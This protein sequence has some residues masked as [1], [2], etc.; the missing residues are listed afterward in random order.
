MSEV[1]E[2]LREKKGRENLVCVTL[3]LLL[4]T[5]HHHF[6]YRYFLNLLK[7]AL[8]FPGGSYGKESACNAGDLGLIPGSRRS[9]EKE[10][11]IHF[12]ILTWRSP[13]TEEPGRLQSMEL[14]RVGHDE[15]D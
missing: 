14:L 13:W 6:S 4:A 12:S 3:Q 11:V 5:Q 1:I 8:G 7:Y 2:I 10:M 15:S 9:P